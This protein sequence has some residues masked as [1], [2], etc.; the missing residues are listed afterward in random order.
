M[1]SDV[2]YMTWANEVDDL[3]AYAPGDSILSVDMSTW[4][5][6]ESAPKNTDQDDVEKL[7]EWVGTSCSTVLST[8]KCED[9]LTL[10][11]MLPTDA[12]DTFVHIICPKSCK[13]YIDS[14]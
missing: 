3:G 13:A 12:S 5:P 10:S 7:L 9:P 6:E 4:N 14:L 11:E 8:L 2:G 1:G